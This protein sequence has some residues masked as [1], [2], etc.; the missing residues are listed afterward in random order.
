MRRL[1]IHW[2]IWT[3]LSL[4]LALALPAT[5]TNSAPYPPL[6]ETVRARTPLRHRSPVQ[7][8]RALLS[9]T[10]AEREKELA[11]RP[12]ADRQII[13]AKVQE[14]EAMPR[15]LREAR[16]CQTELHW[17]LS[18][19]MRIP[20]VVRTNRLREV[21][22]P[23]L[24]M[25]ESLLQKWDQVPV[26][27]QKELLEKQDFIGVYLRLQDSSPAAQKDILGKLSPERRAHWEEEMNRWQ[28]LPEEERS[29]LC[30]QFQRFCQMSGAEQMETV[31]P[32]SEGERKEMERTLQTFNRLPAAQRK[33]C[34]NSFQKFATMTAGDRAQ[35]LRNAARWQAMT[36]HERQL[37]RQLVRA[38][39]PMPPGFPGS[40]PPVPPLPPRLRAGWNPAPPLPPNVTTPVVLAFSTNDFR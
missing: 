6:P 37:W 24:P 15:E 1:R 35:F 26:N 18:T 4:W 5:P 20:P 23:Y 13:L 28:A 33:Q 38:L 34:I 30:A 21:S 22:P 31:G 11:S 17:E 40:A 14:Y 8:F 2:P 19:L 27:T 36:A 32:L 12:P 39:P 9:M 16:L 29:N 25:V 3:A 7:Y 10:S